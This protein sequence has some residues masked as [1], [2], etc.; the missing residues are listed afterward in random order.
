[1]LSVS[2]ECRCRLDA[3]AVLRLGQ[4]LRVL[5]LAPPVA[6]VRVRVEEEPRGRPQAEVQ[7]LLEQQDQVRPNI[8]Y[9]TVEG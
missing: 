9:T 6:R 1:M 7:P 4:L 5:H 3:Q 8:F 2:P